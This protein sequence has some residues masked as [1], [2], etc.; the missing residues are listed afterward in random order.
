MSLTK[1]LNNFL[2]EVGIAAGLLK[3][4][5]ERFRKS[6]FFQ[7]YPTILP[8]QNANNRINISRRY[9]YAYFRIPKAANSTI[10]YNLYY[11]ETGK[12]LETSEEMEQARTAFFNHPGSLGDNQ[13]KNFLDEYYKFSIVRN[14]YTRFL[15]GYFEKIYNKR[16]FLPYRDKL[17]QYLGKSFD[18]SI[19]MDEFLDYLENGG[20][21]DNLHWARQ[22]DI[23]LMPYDEFDFIGKVENLDEDLKFLLRHIF[24]IESEILTWPKHITNAHRKVNLLDSENA[25]RIYSLYEQDFET[26]EYSKKIPD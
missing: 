26:F 7:K 19:S 25:A 4:K 24:K 22:C 12:L 17:A 16:R 11:A 10:V 18:A 23:L 8:I 5:E 20:I 6:P 15:S 2:K 13:L 14:P 1:K 21:N 3:S 9:P